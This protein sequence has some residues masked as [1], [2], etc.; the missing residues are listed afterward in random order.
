MTEIFSGVEAYY[1]VFFL[2]TEDQ[3]R[4]ASGFYLLLAG[5]DLS[6]ALREHLPSRRMAACLTASE[7]VAK[8]FFNLI[9]VHLILL[10]GF[11]SA[12][13]IQLKT[14][15]NSNTSM[16]VNAP[17]KTLAM[18][19]GEL[20]YGDFPF[21]TGLP[22]NY[23]SFVIFVFFVVLVLMNLLTGI[24]FID[25]QQLTNSSMDSTWHQMMMKI[26]I[27]EEFFIR[28]DIQCFNFRVFGLNKETVM[29]PNK[30]NPSW[31][32]KLMTKSKSNR[33]NNQ[34]SDLELQGF[35][36]EVE[37]MLEIT[38]M[39]IFETSIKDE[40]KKILQEKMEKEESNCFSKLE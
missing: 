39:I 5:F 3:R 32:S 36:T 2:L 9:L 23:F 27:Y 24:A 16:M 30:P 1:P 13:Y 21:Q 20:E 15:F 25:V 31:F 14:V 35:M 29:F 37:E 34:N 19:V 6:Y 38:D 40:A 33:Q 7:V 10:L 26:N 18:A 17:M 28:F 22:W 8:S 4:D 12:F 11:M